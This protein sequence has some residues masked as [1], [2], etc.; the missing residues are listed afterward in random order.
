MAN[1]SNVYRGKEFPFR[2]VRWDYYKRILINVQ[3]IISISFYL[4]KCLPLYILIIGCYIMTEVKAV[5][6]RS[7]IN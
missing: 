1:I 6:D 4:K 5:E 3:C 7:Y 2:F